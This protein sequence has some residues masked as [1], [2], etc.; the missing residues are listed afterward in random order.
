[1][2]FTILKKEAVT[3]YDR[4]RPEFKT[5]I[6]CGEIDVIYSFRVCFFVFF[7]RVATVICPLFVTWTESC[8]IIV[9]WQNVTRSAEGWFEMSAKDCQD[10]CRCS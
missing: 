7:V 4:L 8:E 6:R 2:H 10:T 1:M 3:H 9:T 5:L